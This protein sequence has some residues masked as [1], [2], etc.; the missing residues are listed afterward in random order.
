MAEEL[1]VKGIRVT[2]VL[3]GLMRIGSHL[4]AWFKGDE[5]TEFAL[6]SSSAARQAPR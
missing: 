2:T 3:P 5:P 4:Q 6:F 1:R